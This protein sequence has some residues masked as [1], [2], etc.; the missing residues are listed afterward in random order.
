MGLLEHP[1]EVVPEPLSQE[2]RERL[3][4]KNKLNKLG[5]IISS[6]GPVEDKPLIDALFA[7]LQ[8]RASEGRGNGIRII[9][10][11]EDKHDQLGAY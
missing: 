9:E 2:D 6:L 1:F 10:A 7:L 4:Q 11:L 3:W 5:E 8:K